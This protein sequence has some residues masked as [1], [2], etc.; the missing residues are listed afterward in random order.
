LIDAQ[1]DATP[2]GKNGLKKLINK[3]YRKKNELILVI[4]QNVS[5]VE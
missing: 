1:Q 5:V 4:K 2:K 3:I